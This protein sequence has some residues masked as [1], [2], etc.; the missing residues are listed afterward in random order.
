MQQQSVIRGLRS[1]LAALVGSVALSGAGAALAAG[2]SSPL[3]DRA[4]NDVSSVASLQRGARNFVNYCAGCHSTQYVRYNQLARDLGMTEEQVINNLMFA[5]AK[6]TETME[7]A[8]RPAD[9]GRWFG[10]TPPDLSLIVRA[11]G[12][13]YVYNFLRAFYEDPARV[14][15]VNNLML[16]STSMPHVLWELQGTQR[17][18]FGEH[19]HKDAVE[20]VFERFEPGTAGSLSPAEFDDFVRDTVNFL[21]YIA[22]PVKLRRQSLGILVIA[23]LLVFGVLAYLLKVEIWKDVR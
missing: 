10:L 18:V 22:E 16:P 20:V 17:A 21:D 2:G 15:G 7:I 8:M 11:R 5:G 23:F 9:A 12:A 6:I 1:A 13:D 3:A 4:G 14:H 19:Q